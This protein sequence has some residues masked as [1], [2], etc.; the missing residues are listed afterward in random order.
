MVRFRFQTNRD[1]II[2]AA[3]SFA[4]LATIMLVV[5]AEMPTGF[6]DDDCASHCGANCDCLSCL[7][8]LPM[9]VAPGQE[10]NPVDE[11]FSWSV[12]MAQYRC[13]LSPVSDI[14]HPPQLSA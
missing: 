11:P 3:L 5:I 7:P 13:D 2:R 6:C 4:V 9:D 10:L 1:G 14:D 12:P 8:F